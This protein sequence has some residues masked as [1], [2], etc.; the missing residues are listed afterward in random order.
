MSE[1]PGGGRLPGTGGSK[2]LPPRPRLGTRMLNRDGPDVT[3]PCS[4][5]FR[6][7]PSHLR[8]MMW[9]HTNKPWAPEDTTGAHGTMA[10][11]LGDLCTLWPQERNNL[12]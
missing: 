4:L 11:T 2:P 7:S 9:S 1:R 10:Q 12:E 3:L 5:G 8:H 6:R